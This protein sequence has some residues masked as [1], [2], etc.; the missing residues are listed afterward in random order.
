MAKTSRTLGDAKIRRRLA[1]WEKAAE[2][3]ERTGNA[4]PLKRAG[5]ALGESLAKMAKMVAK[6]GTR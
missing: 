3:Y 5:E 1:S 4:K 6:R 2:T